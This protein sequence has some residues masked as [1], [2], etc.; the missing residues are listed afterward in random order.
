MKKLLVNFADS[1]L[2]R[3]QMTKI[4]GGYDPFGDENG[5]WPGETYCVCGSSTIMGTCVSSVEDCAAFCGVTY[6]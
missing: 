5:C 3:E 2:S 1:L 6:P 4:K